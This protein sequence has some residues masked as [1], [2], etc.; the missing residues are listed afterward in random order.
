MDHG[1]PEMSDRPQIPRLRIIVQKVVREVAAQWVE[2][3]EPLA[4]SQIGSRI[5]TALV[6]LT[7]RD[8]EATSFVET[9]QAQQ[10]LKVVRTKRG[11]RWVFLWDVWQAMGPNEQAAWLDRCAELIDPAADA[12]ERKVMRRLKGF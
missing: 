9:L 1:A 8:W 7:G 11:K 2:H 5:N 10:I 4:L 6:R 12:R 3:R